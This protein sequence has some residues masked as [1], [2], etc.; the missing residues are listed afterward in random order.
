MLPILEQLSEIGIIPVVKIDRV[1]DALPLAEALTRGGLP[2]AEITFRTEAA[3][4]AIAAISRAC[5]AMLVGAGT[6][7]TPEQA[8]A[9]MN[10]GARFLVSPGL[11]PR[12]VTH[13]LNKG[14]PFIPGTCT[15]SDL[16]RAIELGL[17][18]VKFFPAEPAGGMPMIRALAAP[19]NRLKFMPTGGI[20]PQ[21]LASYLDDPRILACG[22]SWMVPPDRIAAGDFE[23]IERRTRDAVSAMLDIRFSRVCLYGDNGESAKKNAAELSAMLGLPSP[24]ETADTL[25]GD[26]MG[27][28]PRP[29]AGG[30]GFLVLRTRYLHRAA[31]YYRDRGIPL[32]PDESTGERRLWFKQ[33]F[34]GFRVCL[35]Q[36]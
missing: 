2:C 21:N 7:L 19:Y 29:A 12:V 25:V 22:G 3:S 35:M 34:S 32:Q 28:V 23:E 36:E 9:A 33:E 11:N 26:N 14:Y 1:R 24:D 17:D 8:D 6:V 5:P 15:P 18:V 4:Q 20:G 10:A 31:R 27:F 16:E 30:T 13:C